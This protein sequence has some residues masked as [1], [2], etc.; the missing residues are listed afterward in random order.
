V[1]RCWSGG[2]DKSGGQGCPPYKIL[3]SAFVPGKI[4]W[5]ATVPGKITF[6]ALM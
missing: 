2:G 3:L 5:T 4:K 6:A 1:W